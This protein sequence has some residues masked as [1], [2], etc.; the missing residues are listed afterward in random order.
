MHEDG[1]ELGLEVHAHRVRV[2]SGFR[3]GEV[4][5]DAGVEKMLCMGVH[6]MGGLKGEITTVCGGLGAGAPEDD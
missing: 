6:C 5:A 3:S 2:G 1:E 4:S